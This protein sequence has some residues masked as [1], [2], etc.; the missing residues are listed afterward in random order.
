[1]KDQELFGQLHNL[2]KMK[3]DADWKKSQRALLLSQI[4]A[5]SE[6]AKPVSLLWEIGR[7]PLY[8]MS[9]VVQPVGFMVVAAFVMLTGGFVSL[10]AAQDTKPGDSLYLAKIVGE[11]TQLAL[12]FDEK[13]RTQ[14]SLDFA[15]K[16]A[17]EIEKVMMTESDEVAKDEKVGQLVGDFRREIDLART[18]IAKMSE[19]SGQPVKTEADKT[20]KEIGDLATS[21]PAEVV[22]AGE[23]PVSP[24]E[25]MVFSAGSARE[26]DGI[27][28]SDPTPGV[29]APAAP[30][31]KIQQIASS[32]PQKML[33]QA[34]E[35]IKAEDYAEAAKVLDAADKALSASTGVGEVKGVEEDKG[36]VGTSTE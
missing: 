15:V 18:R 21:A 26:K 23:D 24:A 4:G 20:G 28:V 5:G 10:R 17:E 3:P 13:K 16:R 11:K 36:E 9:R 14:L 7:L 30:E 6:G 31:R 19:L 8:Y 1:M 25:T 29:A 12:T 34:G 32:S 33:E 22:K 35:L 27:S 2:S